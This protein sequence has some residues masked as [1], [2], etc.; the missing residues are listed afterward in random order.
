MFAR[1][2]TYDKK[3]KVVSRLTLKLGVALT[4]V[5]EL[6]TNARCRPLARG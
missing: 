3:Q 1:L 2:V 4:K 5:L 6:D